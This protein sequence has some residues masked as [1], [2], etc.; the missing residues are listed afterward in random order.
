[1]DKTVLPYIEGG[2]CLRFIPVDVA[3]AVGWKTSE[4][5]RMRM[6]GARLDGG[7]LDL[8]KLT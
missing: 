1:M 5:S 4:R 3:S 2:P 8:T 6:Q 7:T